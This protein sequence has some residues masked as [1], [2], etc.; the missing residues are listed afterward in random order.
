MWNEAT[1]VYADILATSGLIGKV[2]F[3]HCLRDINKVPHV[4]AR[5]CYTTRTSCISDD[6]TPGFILQSLM[7]NVMVI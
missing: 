7:D 6:E 2:E 3:T 1:P 4:I 5:D